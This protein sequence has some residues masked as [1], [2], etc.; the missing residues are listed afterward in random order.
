[1]LARES[2]LKEIIKPFL[3]AHEFINHIPRYCFWLDGVSPSKYKKSKELKERLKGIKAFCESSQK[4][5]TRR[6]AEFPFLF[7]EIRHPVIDYILV[8]CHSSER[9]KYVPIGF[10]SKN[11]I[12]GDS[13][14]CIPNATLYEF[15]IV[16]SIMHMA[17]MRYVC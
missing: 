2:Y 15:G 3:G 13:N 17:L 6:L 7:G 4:E 12:V 16:I 1:L 5:A 8:P 11:V 10:V 9:R 14:S